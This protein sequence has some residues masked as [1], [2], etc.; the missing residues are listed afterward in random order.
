[1][2]S[3]VFQLGIV[4]GVAFAAYGIGTGDIVKVVIGSLLV[5]A[6]GMGAWTDR[7]S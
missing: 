4:G 7:P 2:M 5:V 1:M 6:C 3:R